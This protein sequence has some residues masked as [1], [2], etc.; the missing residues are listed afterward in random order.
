MA[1]KVLRFP[2]SMRLFHWFYIT[3]Y[4]VLLIT[5]AFIMYDFLDFLIPV[6]GGIQLSRLI[7][8]FVGVALIITPIIVF[9]FNPKEVLKTLKD[10]YT[11]KLSDLKF[12]K[13]FVVEFFGGHA[14]YEPQ[15]K[16]N[17]GEKLNI[18]LQSLGWFLFAISGLIM[19]YYQAFSP[20]TA[21]YALII[22]DLAY[23]ITIA[24]VI[25]HTYLSTMHPVTKQALQGLV[26]GYVDE[27]YAKNH[28]P[29]WYE[30]VN[31]TNISK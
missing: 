31:K 11:W 5:G 30:E 23:I 29:L 6:F 21:R 18:V 9:F 19:W 27:D 20:D 22:H 10:A 3:F 2:V 24:Y 4:F 14:H 16:Y 12:F 26:T 13:G 15:G 28:H 8:R 7:H 17:V 25:G 1:N